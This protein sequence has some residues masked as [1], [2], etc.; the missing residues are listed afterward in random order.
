MTHPKHWIL[1]C[2]LP[3]CVSA[4]E[5]PVPYG[6]RTEVRAWID[7]LAEE[8]GLP[9][10]RLHKLISASRHQPKVIA[11]ASRPAESKPWHWY[12]KIFLT[13]DRIR[14]GRAY[15]KEHAALLAEAERTYQVPAEVIAAIVGAESSFGRNTGAHP[16]LDTLVTLGFDY[17]PRAEF[18]R[19]QLEQLFLLEG[20][21]GLD[22]QALRGSWAGALGQAQFIPSSYRDFAVDGDH[23]G[24][25]DLWHS[26]ADI[27]FSIANYFRE[28]HWRQGEPV[29]ERVRP[30]DPD[31][32]P[33]SKALR[34]DVQPQQ[35]AALGIELQHP[36]DE[37]VAVHRF[38]N[39]SSLEYWVGYHNFY[40]ITRYNHS[41]LYA[42][43]I[44][45]LSRA[46]K[47]GPRL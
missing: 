1:L 7:R 25:R 45:Q 30:E 3:A 19:G 9:A 40:V 41:A 43:M 42:L 37:A 28:H 8:H 33:L 23:D 32:M 46:L 15:L 21:A 38:E 27:I 12:R 39:S 4:G 2:L 6:E 13:D 26:P 24:R 47:N 18:F 29:A 22:I 31:A 35:L 16:V 34:P 5:P 44:H 17:P 11:S 20:E 36:T 10:E 14:R